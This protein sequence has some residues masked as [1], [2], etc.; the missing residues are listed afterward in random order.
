MEAE[1]DNYWIKLAKRGLKRGEIDPA[2]SPEYAAYLI[3]SQTLLFFFALTSVYHQKRFNV[4]LRA[5]GDNLSSEKL[6]N[7]MVENIRL[8]LAPR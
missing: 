3:D 1:I 6:I 8:C 5:N 2:F 4:F 7:K